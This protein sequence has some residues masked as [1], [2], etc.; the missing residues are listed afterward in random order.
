MIMVIRSIWPWFVSN[1]VLTVSELKLREISVTLIVRSFSSLLASGAAVSIR[2]IRML[3]E[4]GMITV[5]PFQHFLC[6]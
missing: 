4:P 3:S 2:D 6:S 5:R 1:A